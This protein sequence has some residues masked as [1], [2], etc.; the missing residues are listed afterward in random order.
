MSRLVIT[1]TRTTDLGKPRIVSIDK[2]FRG[3]NTAKGQA[4]KT[5][6]ILLNKYSLHSMRTSQ[7]LRT[8]VSG[9][10][11]ANG[12]MRNAYINA[13]GHRVMEV[14]ELYSSGF[15]PATPMPY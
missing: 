13:I 3:L 15:T 1:R 11:A 4:G 8:E 6:S 10:I 2:G 5:L 9:S 14:M 7:H 12:K